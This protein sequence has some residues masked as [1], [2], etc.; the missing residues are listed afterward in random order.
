MRAR[1]W[2][3]LG[4]LLSI[5][6]AAGLRLALPEL[7]RLSV[8][9]RVRA[10][11]G[12]SVTL[13]G[14][15]VALLRGRVVLR[16]FRIADRG[17]EPEPFVEF[18]RLD[19]HLRPAALLRGHLWVRE[20]ILRD[21]VVRVIRYPGDRFNLSDLVRHA[22]ETR[23][24]FDVTVDRFVLVNGTTTL[25]DR[26]LPEPRTW[27]SE[28]MS[29]EARDLSSRPRYG[30]A[31][32]SSVTGGAPVSLRIE[33]LRLYPIDLHATVSIDGLDLAPGQ[34]YLPPESPVRVDR[35]RGS[36]S[37]RVRLDA[38]E[39]L[40]LDATAHV[41]DVVLSRR[42]GGALARVP[43]LTA[44]FDGLHFAPGTMTL[45]RLALDASAAVVDPSAGPAV[46]FAPATLHARVA[47]LTW[48]VSRPATVDLSTRVRDRGSLSVAGTV[49]PPTAASQLRLRLEDF[50]LAPWARFTPLAA[51]LTGVARADLRIDEPLRAGAPARVRGTIAV[52]NVEMA[53]G[54]ERLLGAER[55][56][57]SGLELD[58][59]ERLRIAQLAVR[60]PRAVVERDRA[61]EF[62]LARLGGPPGDAARA[63][64]ASAAP[65]A[66][67]ATLGVAVGQ[68]L[69][70]GGL[71]EW[72][73]RTVTP[74]V[75]A[76][77]SGVTATV[78]GAR[79]PI[80]GPLEVRLAARPPGG[81][82]VEVAGRVGLT[83]FTADARVSARAVDLAPY[84]SYVPVS[85]QLHAWADLDLAVAMPGADASPTA[86]G[87]VVLSRVDVRD[88][89]RSMLQVERAAA[90][91]LEVTWPRRVAAAH[92]A[93]EA[94]WILVERDER[95]AMTL[96]ALL[97]PG[98]SEAVAPGRATAGPA[99]TP[100][101]PALTVRLLTVSEG[102]ARVVDRS[103]APAFAL[104][105]RRLAL[106][107]EG[108]ATAPGSRAEV[109]LKG[110]AGAG[111][112]LALR[113]TLGPVGGPL[114]LDLRG[115]L[116]GF[117]AVRAN[118]YLMRQL[119]WQ[120]AQG[121]LTTR[122]EGR[123]QDGALDARVD[124]Q[125]SRLQVLRA[126]PSDGA[127]GAGAG[128][129]L[130]LVL[131]LMRDSRGDIRMSVPIGGRLDDPRVDFGETIRTAVRT[132]AINAIT[133]P[134]SWIGRLHASP[135]SG[136]ERVEV[137][138]IRFQPGSAALTA[139]GR[140][141]AT[142]VAAFLAQVG[143]VRMSLVPVVSEQDLGVLRREAAEA[144]VER[145]AA[146]GRTSAEDAAARLFRER[147]P[148]RPVPSEPGAVLA[149]LADTE[150][151]PA[152]APALARRRLETLL[153]ALGEAGVARGRLV[154]A[155]LVE[156]RDSAA[157]AIALDLLEPDRPRR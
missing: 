30:S 109:D 147:L 127:G 146:G 60:R 113:G 69:V 51:R 115:E 2:L 41:E 83:P 122:V 58:W 124:V 8:V 54:A 151:S 36:T 108:L 102:G 96:R 142:R 80:A 4:V 112:V 95:G 87:S 128:L 67:G 110:Q 45:E 131:A 155:P 84:Q 123:V 75:R 64:P 85:A 88:G 104:D 117:D 20:A 144:A 27:R 135:D 37:V 35:G 157:G 10:V 145:R 152:H 86:R 116:R 17:G 138:P 154:E 22:G 43:T 82:Q 120:V 90:T 63:A 40:S 137:D 5:V 71:V 76:T 39:G 121:L 77:L 61:G 13:E 119:A 126:S 129:P 26:A 15:D 100:E 149:A 65:R 66:P 29:I 11:T 107:A 111:S 21:P 91:G 42:D 33:R 56:E 81:G 18:D 52:R 25:E 53:S 156:R 16:G 44:A 106:R 68:I 31:V 99:G 46:R 153:A 6:A 12:R 134:V 98:A 32:G 74:P 143:E 59:P 125:L 105:L 118:P 48:P 150:A 34:V 139:D 47:H 9:A 141:Q 132:V 23:R 89:E 79:W 148:G 92:L 101:T 57:A 103:I 97:R 14:V 133:L 28:R 3:A 140:T 50:D 73:D 94:P 114:E 7:I 62:P 70:E 24:V 55:L 136:I 38:K 49:Q 19:L 93:L 130:D 78:G 1:R 72:R